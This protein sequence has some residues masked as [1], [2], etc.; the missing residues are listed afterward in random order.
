MWA[1]HRPLLIDALLA[2][3][4]TALT[5]VSMP[6][7]DRM[8]WQAVALAT[9][10]TAPIVARR[11]A[12]VACMLIISGAVVAYLVL[13][14]GG[15]F[16]L[17]GIGLLVGMF[18]V[19]QRRPTRVAAS[20]WV[21]ALAAAIFAYLPT[22]AGL[23]WPDVVNAALQTVGAWALGD[24]SRRWAERA[25]RL[26]ERAAA[27]E[28]ARIARDLHDVVAHHMSVISL[29]AGVAEYVLDSDPRA[30]RTALTAIADSGGQALGEMRRMLDVLRTD[31]GDTADYHPQPG[32]AQ[33]SE[34]ADRTSAA[35]LPIE[36]IRTG[37][38]RPLPPGVDLCAY[39]ITQE[40]LTNVLKHAGPATAR[41]HLDYGEHAL[42]VRVI[43]DG[44]AS[45]QPTNSTVPHGIA[46]MR[47]RAELYGGVLTAGPRTGGGFAVEL[48]LPTDRIRG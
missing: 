19:A 45:G 23:S 10:S 37:R 6:V 16:P 3:T 18:S 4:L 21:L 7:A 33:L 46:G 26:A 34:L 5:V 12:P 36:L 38:A 13:G 25:D 24:A 11:V 31:R 8:S 47:E 14:Y 28:R 22:A 30:A 42:T 2:A 48:R 40:A 35:G 32:L 29:Q 43:D 15:D 44:R 27:E 20:I 9:M 1:H 39:R 41:I 17:Y